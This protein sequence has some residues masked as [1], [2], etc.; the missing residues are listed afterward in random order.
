MSLHEY[1][2]LIE[3]SNRLEN[4]LLITE[5]KLQLDV[6][7]D[8]WLSDIKSDLSNY[9]S[10]QIQ[11]A[12]TKTADKT[13]AKVTPK[14]VAPPEKFP[15]AG[16]DIEKSFFGSKEQ[17]PDELLG[18]DSGDTLFDK[19][20]T[21]VDDKG[22]EVT[23]TD[24]SVVTTPAATDTSVSPTP[25]TTPISPELKAQLQAVQ[26]RIINPR[27]AKGVRKKQ[28]EKPATARKPKAKK[29]P[30][31]A[32][33]TVPEPETPTVQTPAPVINPPEPEPAVV[34]EPP[35]A[36]VQPPSVP[37]RKKSG[38]KPGMGSGFFD[39]NQNLKLKGLTLYEKTL[40]CLDKL[41]LNS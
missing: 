41:R 12:A 26:D 36:V 14:K 1:K 10:A 2:Y 16:G 3:K 13:A 6:E 30:K 11:R 34:A 40:V 21:T 25:E 19:E 29:D 15:L 24:T 23:T 17:Q 20:T 18:L 37:K 31:Q 33:I 32:W 35:A 27:K 7:L 5:G 39:S 4:T 22:A 8:N 9:F 28:E 38:G